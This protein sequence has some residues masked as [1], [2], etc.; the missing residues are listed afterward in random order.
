MGC[1]SNQTAEVTPAVEV[2][3]RYLDTIYYNAG[4]EPKPSTNTVQIRIYGHML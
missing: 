3:Y 2:D 4:D 1:S